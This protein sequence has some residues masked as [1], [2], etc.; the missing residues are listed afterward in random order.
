MKPNVLYVLCGLPGS[1]KTTYSKQLAAKT[2]AKHYSFDEYS[3][4]NNPR[5]SKQAK[6][7]MFQDVY[8]ALSGGC[9]VILDD[10]HTRLQW[11]LNVLSF[12]NNI[13]CKKVLIVITTQE[14]EC[15]KR[16]QQRERG[17]LPDF[18]IKE[19][20]QK[21]EVPS[22]DEGWDEIIHV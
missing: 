22:L 8:N 17:V 18:V 14:E 16:N 6:Q 5:L 7:Q 10:L 13:S 2:N 3:G 12:V 1:G 4:S 19:L 15:L 20:K 9:N 11:R 21:Y